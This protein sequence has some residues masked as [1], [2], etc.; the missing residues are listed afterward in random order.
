MF[1]LE[2]VKPPD[3][4]LRKYI[5]DY[6]NLPEEGRFYESTAERFRE[7][8]SG[9]E[10]GGYQFVNKTIKS[11]FAKT[12]GSLGAL[13]ITPDEIF[14]KLSDKLEF[15]STDYEIDRMEDGKVQNTVSEHID[16]LFKDLY[17]EVK[18]LKRDGKSTSN[19]VLENDQK[20]NSNGNKVKTTQAHLIQEGKTGIDDSDD[21]TFTKQDAIHLLIQSLELL[22]VYN[23]T[24]FRNG[25]ET[26][27]SFKL[28][29]HTFA[30]S[31]FKEE[32]NEVEAHGDEAMQNSSVSRAS[33]KDDISGSIDM[34]YRK[35]FKQNLQKFLA[36]DAATERQL[37]SVFTDIAKA[38][39]RL[40][41]DPVWLDADKIMTQE[42]IMGL[43][44]L[45][46]QEYTI[47][48]SEY[49]FE[50]LNMQDTLPD[51][52]LGFVRQELINN[53]IKAEE[54]PMCFNNNIVE[55][56]KS[57]KASEFRKLATISNDI[58]LNY[59]DSKRK[60]QFI[61]TRKTMKN[62]KSTLQHTKEYLARIRIAHNGVLH[63]YSMYDAK[64]GDDFL[65][66]GVFS[67]PSIEIINREIDAYLDKLLMEDTE[68]MFKL[69]DMVEKVISNS[70][71]PLIS[72]GNGF[73][74][75]DTTD[76]KG[77]RYNKYFFITL[78][79]EPF[80]SITDN[81]NVYHLDKWL[82][83]EKGFIVSKFS[84]A[85][86]VEGGEP[87]YATACSRNRL[88]GLIIKTVSNETIYHGKNDEFN[89]YA[90]LE[91]YGKD[92]SLHW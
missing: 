84:D 71:E 61:E 92:K 3:M 70:S 12:K 26:Y 44:F 89:R 47:T 91:D 52:K 48:I 83:N 54:I 29:Q 27:N 10:S 85:F 72:D 88:D 2:V 60:N 30:I 74:Y 49:N 25:D 11:A 41:I 34:G 62:K 20:S 35:Y 42:Y 64:K 36:E 24:V 55:K 79:N 65:V 59:L 63:G 82:V 53:N 23:D 9:Y 28:I 45:V 38:C 58:V 78:S 33:N 19:L 32:Q 57:V 81:N 76:E 50:Q 15:S 6:I 67:P 69:M 22:K 40:S 73:L 66:A 1:S 4:G 90:N 13:R 46:N 17:G 37:L 31:R 77:N 39:Q 80:G 21:F 7:N 68:K 56:I 86:L 18:K 14:I 43:K 16:Y 87:I 75:T 8:T 5:V 51:L